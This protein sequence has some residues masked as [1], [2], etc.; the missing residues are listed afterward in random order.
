MPRCQLEKIVS[1]GQTGV[2][3]AALDV[4]IFLD[5]PHGGWCPL[6]R[7]AEDGS[8]PETYLLQETTQRD[9]SIR[10][11]RNIID[12]DGTL[13]LFRN[14]TTGGTDLTRKLALKHRRPLVC[15]DLENQNDD[16]FE[17]VCQ[18]IEEQQINVLNIAGPRESSCRG[19][20]K[21]AERFLVD[22]L[23]LENENR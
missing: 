21:Q 11:E 22:V 5:I 17:R 3:R 12:S 4:A 1:G 23:K 13:I 19:I 7:R 15:I 2:D 8:I 18:W 10:T 14:Q 6:G 9:Y 20:G 16:D